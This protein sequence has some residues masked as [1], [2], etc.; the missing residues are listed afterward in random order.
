MNPRIKAQWIAALRSGDYTQGFGVLRG[1]RIADGTIGHC[2]LGVLCNLYVQE[3]GRGTWMP[4]DSESAGSMENGFAQDT[5]F[6]SGEDNQPYTTFPPNEVIQWA[7]YTEA[8]QA[9]LSMNHL[10][11]RNDSGETFWQIAQRIEESL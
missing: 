11:G 9:R 4:V 8:D 6:V 2:C 7:G 10:A 5:T 3:T 1:T